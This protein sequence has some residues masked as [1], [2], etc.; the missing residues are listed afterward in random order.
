MKLSQQITER[1]VAPG[2]LACWWLG[3]SGFVFKTSRGTI[4][5]ID[6]YLSNSVERMFNQPR[7]FPPPILPAEVRA[8]F[9]V[10]THWHED[11]LDPD[12]IPGIVNANPGITLIMPP[13]AMAHA[14][15]WGVSRKN[16]QPLTTGQKLAVADIEIE[17]AP[18]R[19]DAGVVGWEVPDAMGVLLRAEGRSVYH[20]GDT[21]YDIRLRM[22]RHRRPDVALLCINGAGGNMNTHEAALLAWQ[23]G[24]RVVV[25]MHHLIW[26]GNPAGTEATLDPQQFAETYR[27]LGGAGRVALPEVGKEISLA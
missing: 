5:Y 24:S 15:H 9:V 27:R 20:C 21:E 13:S 8:D 14:V 11:H 6:P 4:G 22:L 1:T 2:T 18:A 7:A 16:I 17:H 10:S 12:T 19:H 3:G 26:A 23:L 25:P